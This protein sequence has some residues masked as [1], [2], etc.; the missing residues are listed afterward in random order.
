[1]AR[2]ND[3]DPALERSDDE[4]TLLDGPDLDM[5]LEADSTDLFDA[6]P[7]CPR[8]ASAF[9]EYDRDYKAHVCDDCGLWL[10]D[11]PLDGWL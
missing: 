11:E 8:C 9:F 7:C 2:N 3:A 10:D 4:V 5:I 6:E 1:M